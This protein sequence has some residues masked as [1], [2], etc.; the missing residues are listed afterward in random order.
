[1]DV[2]GTADAYC[3]VK[4]MSTDREHIERHKTAIVERTLAPHWDEMFVAYHP[5]IITS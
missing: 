4:L 1:M 3:K 5:S 2:E